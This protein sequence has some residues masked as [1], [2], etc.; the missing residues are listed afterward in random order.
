MKADIDSPN[1]LHEATKCEIIPSK[2]DAKW[3]DPSIKQNVTAAIAG[4]AILVRINDPYTMNPMPA[5][6]SITC[7]ALIMNRLSL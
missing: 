2:L 5:Q 6:K 7:S 3:N 1:R 4:V